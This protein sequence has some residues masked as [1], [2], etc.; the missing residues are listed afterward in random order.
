[1]PEAAGLDLLIKIIMQHD[2]GSLIAQNDREGKA[3]K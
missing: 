1:M 2:H 3:A